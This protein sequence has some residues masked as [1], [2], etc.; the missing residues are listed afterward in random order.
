MQ[1]KKF[2]ILDLAIC[3][4]LICSVCLVI[5]RDTVSEIFEEPRMVT[6]EITVEFRGEDAVSR[7]SQTGAK[8]ADFEPQSDGETVISVNLGEM[9][10]IPGSVTVPD[11]ATVVFTC[12]G[13]T[14]FGR[15]YNENGER[16]Y[17][18][19]QSAF[20][21]DGVRTEGYTVSVSGANG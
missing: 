6:L 2:N 10:I 15:F 18:N 5:F 17:E 9:T 12:V 8:N 20:T 21:L 4:V 11:H 3:L 7:V 1:K 14:R 19:S 16:I 13:Y